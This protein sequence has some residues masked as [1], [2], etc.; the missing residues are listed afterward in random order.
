MWSVGLQ[1]VAAKRRRSMQRNCID[2][3]A[4]VANENERHRYLYQP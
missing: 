3:D 4:R 2:L 1:M